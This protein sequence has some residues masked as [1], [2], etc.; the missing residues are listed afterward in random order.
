MITD[1]QNNITNVGIYE[2]RCLQNN[3]IY[4]GSS[5]NIDLRLKQHLNCLKKNKH[6]SRYLQFAW[7]KYGDKAF[8]VKVLKNLPK[9]TD[10]QKILLVEQK[11]LDRLQPWKSE[12]GFNTN[13]S[14]I[15]PPNTKGKNN[16]MFGKKHT[17]E[18]K[19]KMRGP[20]PEL[21]I[22]NKGK[23]MPERLNDPNWVSPNI[24]QIPIK[25][26][27]INGQIDTKTHYEW[28]KI[29]VRSDYICSNKR[30]NLSSLGWYYCLKCCE[31][32]NLNCKCL[33]IKKHFKK[34][35]NGN[36]LLELINVNGT[37]KTLT[38]KE[39]YKLK[40]YIYALEKNSQRISKGWRL[41][42]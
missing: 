17:E 9:N 5:K 33:Q 20:R 41:C 26:K 38:R 12:I 40:V 6:D 15:K 1:I 13:S 25:L 34:C 14:A 11:Y 10:S 24:I 2:I 16:G 42:N 19:A 36:D 18:A 21:S 39:W 35:Y 23:T 22:K 29:K 30:K 7:V 32:K 8:I 31:N 27:H 3:K 4:I 28:K 37:K